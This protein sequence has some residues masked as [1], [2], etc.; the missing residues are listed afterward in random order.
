[1]L[2]GLIS[3]QWVVRRVLRGHTDS[4]RILVDRY[5]GM[6]YGLAYAHLGNAP[7]AED[8]VQET[9]VRLWQWLDRVAVESTLGP[10]LV[11]VAKN[12]VV[13]VARHRAREKAATTGSNGLEGSVE[14]DFA[15]REMHAAIWNEL[16]RLNAENREILVLSYFQ[17][18]RA[19]DIARLLDIS[20]E[21]ATKRLQRAR[22]EMGRRL[23]A[24]AGGDII[25][26]EPS[27]ERANRIM[28][29]IAAASSPWKAGVAVSTAG[30]VV[31]GATATKLIGGAAVLLA[32]AVAS[33]YLFA[34]RP[35]HVPS[36][37][38]DITAASE[39]TV[40]DTE[41]PA[42][43]TLPQ[44][45]QVKSGESA[46]APAEPATDSSEDASELVPDFY[47]VVHGVVVD[48]MGRPVPGAQVSLSNEHELKLD[49]LYYKWDNPK[50]GVTLT[51]GSDHRGYFC[52][53]A[54]PSK[55]EKE[56]CRAR[57]WA[58]KP[59]LFGEE[60]VRLNLHLREQYVEVVMR[61]AEPLGGVVVDEEGAPVR[62]AFVTAKARSE[63]TIVTDRSGHFLFEHLEPGFY[64]VL[65][66]GTGNQFSRGGPFETGTMDVV[67]R[68]SRGC[69]IMGRVIGPDGAGVGGFRLVVSQPLPGVRPFLADVEP[70]GRFYIGGL[71][72]GEYDLTIRRDR[73]DASPYVLRE[74]VRVQVQNEV[75]NLD[76]H[77]VRGA[78]IAGRVTEA[79]TGGG[80]AQATVK[81]EQA[82]SFASTTTQA[83][84]EYVLDGVP[85]GE[86]KAAAEKDEYLPA[87]VTLNV[88]PGAVKSGVDFQLKEMLAV[89][90][91]V[92]DS[93]GAPVAGAS[94]VGRF[95]VGAEELS[96]ISGNDG[97]FRLYTP[98]QLPVVYLQAFGYGGMMS[99]LAGPV[100]PY[101]R[102]HELRLRESGRLE[103]EVVDGAGEPIE[104]AF[105][106]A[107]PES[108]SS[109]QLGQ[110]L[111][112]SLASDRV[113][114]DI[115]IRADSH[116]T[117]LSPPMLP[118]NYTIEILTSRYEL[119]EAEAVVQEGKTTHARLVV[120]TS[121]FGAI[122]GFITSHGKPVP[123]AG[124]KPAIDKG[125]GI[126]ESTTSGPD[127][128]YRLPLVLAGQGYVE[129][130]RTDGLTWSVIK[131]P[132]EVTAGQTT[133]LDID[134]GRTG[135]GSL[136][137]QV[138][139]DGQ[140]QVHMKVCLSSAGAE[141]EEAADEERTGP[142]GTFF[143]D[144]LAEGSYK[145][146]VKVHC[147]NPPYIMQSPEFYW[148]TMAVEVR[149]G[150]TAR[151]DFDL[152]GSVVSGEVRGIGQGERAYVALAGA[153]W[154]PGTITLESL[155]RLLSYGIVRSE[156]LTQDGPFLFERLL[157]GNYVIAAVV[158]GAGQDMTTPAVM[159]GVEANRFDYRDLPLEP[160]QSAAVDLEVRN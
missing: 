14:P 105:V 78:R 10:W 21:A 157:P 42:A 151:A 5:G 155:D 79:A 139:I 96:A 153:S 140:P 141:N 13:D 75:T 33:Y 112:Q 67:I 55:L 89:K 125:R 32:A 126:V 91:I 86:V 144:E 69:A 115:Y 81:A 106:F 73:K 119:G 43:G 160:G 118:G 80:I 35:G 68:L 26:R 37:A 99:E 138:L 60:D 39:F 108:G 148:Q 18:R 71:T 83:N 28:A 124:V 158:V 50:P 27:R 93:E 41:I 16:S 134:I 121:R 101:D 44:A 109:N 127:G 104:F 90:G 102:E 137:G 11:R 30:A 1:M 59:G 135:A 128:Y 117:F 143:F 100:S 57:V 70:G 85:V 51:T 95:T 46:T 113:P 7:D 8:V 12:L 154:A 123:R 130:H 103:G 17:G 36:P 53:D 19:K 87:E 131:E 120:D 82:G 133:P 147:L 64:E 34:P 97:K 116:G 22:A 48:T 2:E 47:A 159:A 40:R 152:A 29:A 3:D 142:D 62:D 66:L 6:L 88:E 150:E 25:G 24:S 129:V 52:F 110:D 156:T 56:A 61:P 72:A 136:A 94:V 146:A 23:L 38:P 145:V 63:T 54:V 45:H 132:V 31:V 84:G 9:F 15:R 49:A 98:E 76:V 77:V 111:P 92:L 58:L 122:E 65:A 4:F 114:T 20:A 107:T 149:A 74:P